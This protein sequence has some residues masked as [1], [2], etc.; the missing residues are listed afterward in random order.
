VRSA[1]LARSLDRT[2]DVEHV[3]EQLERE[4]DPPSVG[5]QRVD[6]G[7]PAA[8]LAEPAGSLE[9][10]RRLQLAALEVALDRD[11]GVPRVLALQQLAASE[12]RRGTRQQPHLL[13]VPVLD[14]LRECAGEQ[15]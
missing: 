4:A 6:R 10:T 7:G 9:Q 11:V 12:R 5:R 1:R 2:A 13:G 14:K 3:V 8:A 15:G